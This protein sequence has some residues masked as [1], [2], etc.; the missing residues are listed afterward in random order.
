LDSPDSSSHVP[1]LQQPAHEPPPQLHVPLEHESPVLH[2]LQAAPP[3]PH[4]PDDW[5]A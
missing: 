3:A 5:F 4:W 1:P 2:A